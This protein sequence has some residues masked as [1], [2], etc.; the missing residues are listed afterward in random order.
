MENH[1]GKLHGNLKPMKP[2]GQKW[3]SKWGHRASIRKQ[4]V[5]NYEEGA[6]LLPKITV[7]HRFGGQPGQSTWVGELDFEDQG[8][9]DKRKPILEMIRKQLDRKHEEEEGI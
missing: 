9:N 3:K 4:R 7:T 6:G 5:E 2:S 8:W 1:N